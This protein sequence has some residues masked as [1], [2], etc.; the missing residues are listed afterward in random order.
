[1]C[2][3]TELHIF[4]SSPWKDFLVCSS[5]N[6]DL[7]SVLQCYNSN[8][9][10]SCQLGWLR[11]SNLLYVGS[12]S[13]CW[14]QS[15]I[16]TQHVHIYTH[17]CYLLPHHCDSV[18]NADMWVRLEEAQLFGTVSTAVYMF[19]CVCVCVC[20]CV[21]L[22]WLGVSWCVF[23]D[24]YVFVWFLWICASVWIITILFL[25]HFLW[26]SLPFLLHEPQSLKGYF[27]PKC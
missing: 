8:L 24:V 14:R 19:L 11:E 3:L 18:R 1:M 17:R 25:S 26:L 9:A 15:S 23:S 10:H 27:T 7:K 22:N 5:W 16:N 2:F 6:C 20:V 21:W 13:P 4:F 12:S